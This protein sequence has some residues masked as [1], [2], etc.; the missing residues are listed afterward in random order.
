MSGPF[1]L[2]TAT[3]LMFIVGLVLGVAATVFV[4]NEIRG[5]DGPEMYPVRI[6]ADSRG[7][8]TNLNCLSV[9]DG[10]YL[11]SGFVT[12]PPGS[13]ILKIGSFINFGNTGPANSK[14][15]QQSNSYAYFDTNDPDYQ[16]PGSG[17]LYFNSIVDNSYNGTGPVVGGPTPKYCEAFV[18]RILH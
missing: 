14:N 12:A 10:S 9:A 13:G 17:T 18:Q 3:K 4:T 2:F 16:Q 7:L 15:V 6:Q 8:L 1:Q 5:R 11:V